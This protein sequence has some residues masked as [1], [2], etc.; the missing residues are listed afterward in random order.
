MTWIYYWWHSRWFCSET[1]CS[2]YEPLA[3]TESPRSLEAPET[4]FHYT[5]CPFHTSG[6]FLQSPNPIYIFII[7]L[8]IWVVFFPLCIP[9]KQK[10]WFL[11]LFFAQSGLAFLLLLHP[12]PKLKTLEPAL[13]ET[14]TI[15]GFKVGKPKGVLFKKTQGDMTVTCVVAPREAVSLLGFTF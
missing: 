13:E 7:L 4:G 6:T 9:P 1:I 11:I 12:R 8:S 10:S 3:S 14:I 15:S 5:V 2:N